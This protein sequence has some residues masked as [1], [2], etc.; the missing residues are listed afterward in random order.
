MLNLNAFASNRSAEPFL[1]QVHSWEN[2]LAKVQ[3]VLEVWMQV[4]RK[5]TYLEGIFIGSED[6]RQQLPNEA[7]RFDT[8]DKGWHK[9]MSETLKNTNALDA[10]YKAERRYE[11]LDLLRD[12]LDTCQRGL[13]EYLETKRSVLPSFLP[14]PTAVLRVF[15]CFPLFLPLSAA[16]AP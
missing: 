14:F 6:I 16:F 13:S 9:I 11:D 10:C 2:R 15:S 7:K 8:I 5:W 12:E 4:Q 3:E 1:E